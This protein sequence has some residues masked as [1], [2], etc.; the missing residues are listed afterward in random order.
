MNGVPAAA[1]GCLCVAQAKKP[2]RLI[3]DVCEDEIVPIVTQRIGQ[4]A[5]VDTMNN[6][7][8]ASARCLG[9]PHPGV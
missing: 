5:I 3:P 9:P 1:G 8:D 2:G 4:T 7:A 6:Q